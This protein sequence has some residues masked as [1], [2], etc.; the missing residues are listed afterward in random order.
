[1]KNNVYEL[2]KRLINLSGT[3]YTTEEF[4]ELLEK[5]NKEI[6]DKMEKIALINKSM[7]S[8]K[9]FDESAEVMDKNTEISLQKKIKKDEKTLN[10][11]KEKLANNYND[12]ERIAINLEVAKNN[13][14]KY[15][16]LIKNLTSKLVANNQNKDNYER[17]INQNEKKLDLWLNEMRKLEK[18]LEENLLEEE[19][20]RATKDD[21]EDI[22]KNNK[23]KLRDI[24]KCLEN[25]LNYFDHDLK[26]KDQEEL[27]KIK[28]ELNK[29]EKDKLNLLTTPFCL[30]NDL[31]NLVSI[32]KYSE[33]SL[34]LRELISVLETLPYINENDL[35]VLEIEL[36]QL[37]KKFI[38]LKERISKN[39][40]SNQKDKYLTDRQDD[41]NTLLSDNENDIKKLENIIFEI[42][43]KRVIDFFNKISTL[44]VPENMLSDYNENLNNLLEYSNLLNNF[45]IGF[46]KDFNQ[47]IKDSL[48]KI[49]KEIEDENAKN[50]DSLKAKDIDE[51]KETDHGIRLIERRLQ[52]EKS[53]EEIYEELELLLS[54]LEFDDEDDL[55][56]LKVID[57]IEV[58]NKKDEVSNSKEIIAKKQVTIDD[59][60]KLVDGK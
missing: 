5:I 59:I 48:L 42:D 22:L 56:Y 44:E 12:K 50:D 32:N 24:Q 13:M 19:L 47:K 37:N 28:K 31:Y 17:I 6:N 51:I 60:L 40:Y 16:E 4:N 39:V 27:E 3:N 15:K 49:E 36:K 41:L 55:Q 38:S 25:E 20:L 52:S 1:M 23:N 33:A 7:T 8:E 26:K 21:I 45:G 29:L 10:N 2:I 9:Y 18:E 35:N 34:K 43:N 57:I 30:A 58:E 53:I 11:I 46:L 54:S 14:E